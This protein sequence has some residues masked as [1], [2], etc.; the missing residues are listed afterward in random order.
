MATSS[1]FTATAPVAHDNF[2]DA[3]VMTLGQSV[4]GSTVGA[5]VE[6]GEPASC[7]TG[8]SIWY[9]ATFTGNGT[10]RADTFGSDFDTELGVYTGSAVGGLTQVACND[11][12]AAILQSDVGFA[13][14]AGTTYYFRVGGFHGATGAVQFTLDFG[15]DLPSSVPPIIA[16]TAP[17][18]RSWPPRASPLVLASASGTG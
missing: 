14:V 10:V 13:A 8:G 9:R 7:G 11:D 12:V 2:A 1:P 16:T 3:Q 5:G 15:A 17:T 18:S 4:L 6:P